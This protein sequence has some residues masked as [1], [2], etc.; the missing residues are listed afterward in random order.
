[1]KVSL[2]KLGE[3]ALALALGLLFGSAVFVLVK[4]TLERGSTMRAAEDRL[5]PAVEIDQPNTA[6]SHILRLGGV[7]GGFEEG[8]LVTLA[9]RRNLKFRF[10]LGDTGKEADN[11]FVGVAAGREQVAAVVS[12]PHAHIDTRT[13]GEGLC[14]ARTARE[15]KN[16]RECG[17]QMRSHGRRVS[18]C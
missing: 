8:H 6:D 12:S 11:I 15:S 9:L 17:Q 3:L 5:S 7:V 18:E 10:G 1:V 4:A 13:V 2:H 16:E 14:F